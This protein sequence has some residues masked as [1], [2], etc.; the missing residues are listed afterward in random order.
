MAPGSEYHRVTRVSRYSETII[1]CPLEG[2]GDS[3]ISHPI[4]P[5]RAWPGLGCHRGTPWQLS[6]RQVTSDHTSQWQAYYAVTI[7]GLVAAEPRRSEPSSLVLGPPDPGPGR[8]RI[9]G[10][11]RACR[12]PPGPAQICQVPAP[13]AA[14]DLLK[15]TLVRYG[16]APVTGY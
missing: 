2:S 13:A 11:A 6:H 15:V 5:G 8:A 10:G 16:T 14:N 7:G 3:D 4:S 12:A 1:D 9:T